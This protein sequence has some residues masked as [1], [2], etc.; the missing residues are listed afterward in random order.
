[1]A[2]AQKPQQEQGTAVAQRVPREIT[3]AAVQ[4]DEG[5]EILPVRRLPYDTL[6][7]AIGSESNDFGTPGALEV[8]CGNYNIA[9]RTGGRFV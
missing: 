7:I 5:Q 1:M 8:F 4:D 9:E 3:V 2:A 6:V